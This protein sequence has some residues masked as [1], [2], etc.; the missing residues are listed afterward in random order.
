[1]SVNAKPRIVITTGDPAGIGPEIILKGLLH[2]KN[3]NFHFIPIIIGNARTYL[4]PVYIQ[5]FKSLEIP[6]CDYNDISVITEKH[7]VL[8]EPEEDFGDI[9]PGEGS[10]RSGAAA[11]KYLD[12]ALELLGK[13][14]ADILLTCPINKK[15]F[16][17]AGYDFAGHTDYLKTKTG[18]S[19]AL[20]MF[21]VENIKVLL[22]THH[23]PIKDVPRKI[24]KKLIF[25]ILDFL[26]KKGPHYGLRD[27]K[28]A[29]A[30]LN[31]HSGEDG[32]LG[33]E[34]METILPAVTAAR[35]FFPEI[36]G[37]L[38]ADSIFRPD[39]R[40]KYDL[41]IT[42][43]HDQGLTGVKAIGTAVNITLGLPFIRVSPDHGTA[44]EIAGKSKADASSFIK[45]VETGLDLYYKS[46]SCGIKAGKSFNKM[47]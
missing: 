41:I 29:V 23:I 34:D 18:S 8:M 38:P 4:S 37:P 42:M 5:S 43:Y 15:H 33:T 19:E 44:Y 6:V 21:A 45:A 3:S 20:M 28:I 17:A 14:Q 39:I 16:I 46:V 26:Y 30:G 10:V 36:E 11:G 47:R 12:I 35:A 22:A 13:K 27:L 25:D 24:T 40:K 31:P 2:L 32:I 1:L 9:Q 7:A